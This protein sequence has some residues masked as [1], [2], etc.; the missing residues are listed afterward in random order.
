MAWGNRAAAL[1]GH[2]PGDTSRG[3][4]A[5]G[6]KP[7]LSL[8]PG[9]H[10]QYTIAKYQEGSGRI[11]PYRRVWPEGQLLIIA[12]LSCCS[13]RCTPTPADDYFATWATAQEKESLVCE[14]PCNGPFLPF[15]TRLLPS[16][17][18]MQHDCKRAALTR[19]TIAVRNDGA[20]DTAESVDTAESGRSGGRTVVW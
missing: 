1:Y 14:G 12:G 13:S 7:G 5:G 3:T 16:R 17:N 11:R 19:N 15:A 9:R 4:Q 6:H 10:R 2:K 18:S 8:P 20:A